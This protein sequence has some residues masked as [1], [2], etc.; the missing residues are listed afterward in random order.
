MNLN[1][2]Q[3]VKAAASIG[4]HLRAVQNADGVAVTWLDGLPPMT[5][6]AIQA[7]YDALPPTPTIYADAH[8]FINSIPDATWAKLPPK[9]Q[10]LLTS[11]H[12][13]VWTND[14]R[15]TG[16]AAQLV[17]AGVLTQEEVDAVLA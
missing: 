6:E 8:A 10:A 2:E 11:W 17:A 15:L 1:H 4:R 12:G 13:E 5:P 9:A 3:I 14:A 16:M 7:A